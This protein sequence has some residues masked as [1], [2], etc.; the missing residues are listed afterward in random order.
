MLERESTSSLLRTRFVARTSAVPTP[1]VLT[2]FVFEA[3]LSCPFTISAASAAFSLMTL[4]ICT[5]MLLVFACLKQVAQL[6]SG[7][8][9][10]LDQACLLTVNGADHGM[11]CTC[12]DAHYGRCT[13]AECEVEFVN[14]QRHTLEAEPTGSCKAKVRKCCS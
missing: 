6:C 8:P 9:I 12:N 13:R 4:L 3:A 14:E 5:R 1:T 11:Q 10:T 2:G 7:A